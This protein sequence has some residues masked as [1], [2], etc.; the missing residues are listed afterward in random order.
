[1]F[2]YV[3]NFLSVVFSKN[4]VALSKN[5]SNFPSNVFSFLWSN[6][7]SLLLSIGIHSVILSMYLFPLKS[8]TWCTSKFRTCTTCS[9]AVFSSVNTPV[10]SIEFLSAVTK[11]GNVFAWW[12]NNVNL[13]ATWAAWII[14]DATGSVATSPMILTEPSVFF[15]TSN[16]SCP[17]IVSVSLNVKMLRVGYIFL[18]CN[19]NAVSWTRIFIVSYIFSIIPISNVVLPE[20]CS[21]VMAV[22]LAPFTKNFNNSIVSSFPLS[23]TNCSNVALFTSNFLTKNAHVSEKLGLTTTTREPSFISFIL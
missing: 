16:P 10:L 1:M 3:Y 18:K 2:L 9:S 6:V 5:L 12:V 21:P 4:L 23:L 14:Q 13:D 8:F 7:Y 20:P 22:I 11:L 15:W 17:E 19:S